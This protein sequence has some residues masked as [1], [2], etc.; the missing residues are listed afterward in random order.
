MEVNQ[1]FIYNWR[2][3]CVVQLKQ[4]FADVEVSHYNREGNV[5]VDDA[6]E[7]HIL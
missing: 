1:W 3:N 4:W 2:Y 6:V 7:C 5:A